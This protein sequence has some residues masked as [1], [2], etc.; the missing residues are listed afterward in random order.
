MKAIE[1]F[2]QK[3]DC[4]TV[5]TDTPRG[6]ICS[7][8]LT[9]EKTKKQSIVDTYEKCRKNLYDSIKLDEITPDKTLSTENIQTV[10]G[11]DKFVSELN[12]K[13]PQIP[14]F[15]QFSNSDFNQEKNINAKINFVSQDS[16]KAGPASI[17]NNGAIYVKNNVIVM[18]Q[19]YGLSVSMDN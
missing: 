8:I 15:K 9:K 5:A 19:F 18:G 6:R 2:S 12:S 14:I 13:I 7:Q 11:I 1:D 10:T 17:G 3:N 4:T 16:Y